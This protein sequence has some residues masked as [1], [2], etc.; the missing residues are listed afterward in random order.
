MSINPPTAKIPPTVPPA[1]A[2]PLKEL[3]LS[4]L[5]GHVLVAAAVV[6]AESGVVFVVDAVVVLVEVVVVELGDPELELVVAE[7]V[8]GIRPLFVMNPSVEAAP[9]INPV[10]RLLPSSQHELFPQQ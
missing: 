2:P 3:P 9:R 4:K 10:E 1:I 8:T 5:G 6:A 7:V